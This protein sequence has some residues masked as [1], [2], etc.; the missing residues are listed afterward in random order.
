MKQCELGFG[1]MRLPLLDP[2]DRSSVDFDKTGSLI[3]LYL[4]LGGSYFDTAFKY[5]GKESEN[6]V[7]ICLTSQYPRARFILADKLTLDAITSPDEMESFFQRQL[8][9]CGVDYFDRYLIHSLG[10]LRWQKA[11]AWGCFSFLSRI[12][13][14]ERV[15][16]IGFSY[17][18]DAETLDLILSSYPEIDFV[19]LQLNYLDWNDS[20]IQSRECWERAVKHGK[21]ISAMEPLKG[22]A[23][24]KFG[25]NH[26]SLPSPS[27][28]GLRFIAEKENVEYVLSGMNEQKQV[29]ENMQA[30]DQL[31]Q[32]TEDERIE[33]E[34]IRER[35][36][37]QRVIPCSGCDYCADQCPMKIPVSRILEVYN[38]YLMTQKVNLTNSRIYLKNLCASGGRPSKCLT[39]GSCE[40]ICPQQIPIRKLLSEISIEL[41]SG[42]VWPS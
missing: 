41:E 4:S 34:R 19:Q 20:V 24:L 16:E 31:P 26:S 39:C 22:G 35:Y 25:S 23:L 42:I 9:K 1:L 13:K 33:L 3:D 6:A 10:P 29:T 15:K 2:N 38:S 28:L 21:R 11:Q 5:C 12:R 17:H 36:S 18:G 40:R 8:K 14:E 37:R 7:R 30:I 27:N 32:L